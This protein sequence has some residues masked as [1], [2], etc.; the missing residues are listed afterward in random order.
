VLRIR[1]PDSGAG[2]DVENV[3]DA[4]RE[5]LDWGEVESAV[6]GHEEEVMLEI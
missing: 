3:V 1:G 4:A 5:V 2:C 6:E